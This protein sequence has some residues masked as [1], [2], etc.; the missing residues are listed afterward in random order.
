MNVGMSGG[1][2]MDTRGGNACRAR[3][4]GGLGGR[5]CE[6]LGGEEARK[7]EEERERRGVAVGYLQ[8]T[9]DGGDGEAWMGSVN[10]RKEEEGDARKAWVDTVESGKERKDAHIAMVRKRVERG[11]DG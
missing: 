10:Q 11:H 9:E 2:R 6:A 8:R 4:G 3:K 7:R 5:K 1:R